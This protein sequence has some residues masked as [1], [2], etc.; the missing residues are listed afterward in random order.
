[1]VFDKEIVTSPLENAT[2]AE[3][4]IASSTAVPKLVFVVVPQVPD[5]S[6][7]ATSSIFKFE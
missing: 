7:V 3:P 5:C 6:P 2:L 4:V 1:L